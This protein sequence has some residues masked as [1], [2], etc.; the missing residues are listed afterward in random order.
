MSTYESRKEAWLYQ[1]LADKAEHKERPT[2]R[3]ILRAIIRYAVLFLVIELTGVAIVLFL[4]TRN[5]HAANQRGTANQPPPAP[6]DK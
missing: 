4:A 2:L 5:D 1:R 6:A 3:K